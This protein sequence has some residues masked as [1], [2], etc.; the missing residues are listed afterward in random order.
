ME[1]SLGAVDDRSLVETASHMENITKKNEPILAGDLILIVDA[2]QRLTEIREGQDK[3][4]ST[5]EFEVNAF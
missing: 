3:P 4:P 1:D 2:F 5:E